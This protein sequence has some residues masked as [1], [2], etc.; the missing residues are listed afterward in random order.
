[1]ATFKDIHLAERLFM[2]GYPFHRFAP[3]AENPASLAITSLR[4]PLSACTVALI[5]TAAL[6]LPDQ[7]PFDTSKKLG[8]PSFR[9]LPGLVSPQ[10]LQ[11]HHLSWA[12]DQ[13][14]ILQDR[15]LALPVDR[16][17]EMQRRGEIQAVA[18]HH[19]SFMGAISGPKRLIKETAPEV[20][21]RLLADQVDVVLLTPV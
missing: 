16:L 11:M 3:K 1:M 2:Q 4:K 5:T 18:P 14:G 21:R 10:E 8:D 15:N 6:S 17:V 9:E 13:R 20:A 19:Y 7:P 12:F